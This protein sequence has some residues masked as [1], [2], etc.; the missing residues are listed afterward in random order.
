MIRILVG[1]CFTRLFLFGADADLIL[2][3]GKVVTVDQDFSIQQAVVVRGSEIVA[4]G[5]DTAVMTA[6]RGPGTKVIQ[7]LHWSPD[8][9]GEGYHRPGASV[10][11]D[12][13]VP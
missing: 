4:I 11:N 12:P 6:E 5:S 13:A 3:N 2:R 10:T 9:P 8:H 7:H 1:L